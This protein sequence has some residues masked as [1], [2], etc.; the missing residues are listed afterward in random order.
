MSRFY[1]YSTN[2]TLLIYSQRPDATLVA[3]Y[4]HWKD[5]F[6]RHVLKGEKGIRIIAPY[7]YTK[8]VERELKDPVTGEPVLD[9]DG[10]IR[11]V[12]IETLA[13]GF[14]AATVFDISQTEGKELPSLI[15]RD[16]TGDID[17]FNDFMDAISYISPVPVRFSDIENGA[18]GFFDPV[19][20]YI[21]IQEGLSQTQTVKTAIHELTHALLHDSDKGKDTRTKEIEAE[22]VAYTVCRHYGIDTSEYSFSYIAGWSSGRDA[23][24]L[25]SSIETIRFTASDVI[26]RMDMRLKVLENDRSVPVTDMLTDRISRAMDEFLYTYD[27]QDYENSYIT[28]DEALS[29]IRR[30]LERKNSAELYKMLDKASQSG[31]RSVA[32]YT[33]M[34]NI[35]NDILVFCET[36]AETQKAY[37]ERFPVPEEELM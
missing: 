1:N 32:M 31:E 35:R 37:V 23:E 18:K 36:S 9:S 25:K 8:T 14:R 28:R 27:R 12:K 6:G 5:H 19:H 16:L 21:C 4:N 20:N 33:K 15:P 17:N 2:N 11:I 29:S 13:H 24:E 7:Q 22:A 3:G 26:N 10:N 34:N 30:T